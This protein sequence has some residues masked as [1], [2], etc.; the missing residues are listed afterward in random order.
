[1][2]TDER[3]RALVSYDPDTG[4]LSRTG[5]RYAGKALGC[6][7]H[8]GVQVHIGGTKYYAHRV[9]WLLMTGEW[10]VKCIDHING[11]PADNRWQN[12]RQA[13]MTQNAWN[14]RSV[15]NASGVKGVVWHGG[16]KRWWAT[17]KKH[18]VVHSC[19]YHKRLEDAEQAVRKAREKLHGEY[20]R[21]G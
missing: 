9:A 20:A 7:I 8:G 2:T 1:M 4:V 10:P 14:R 6:L 18:G 11:N 19:G 17:V 15:K 21:H 16:A 12:L 3:L 13:D 5:G